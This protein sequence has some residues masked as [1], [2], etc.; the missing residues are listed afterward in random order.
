MTDQ[1]TPV[2]WWVRRDFRLADNP[3]LTAALQNGAPVVPLYV[4]D[5]QD[6]GLGA[7]PKFRLGLAIEHFAKTLAALG[8]RLILRRG[9][10]LSVLKDLMR[11]T[12]AR[13][14]HWSRLYDPEA[15]ARD[16]QIKEQLKARG[17]EARSHG[18]RLLF[19]PWTVQNKAG[20][21]FRVYTPFWKTVCQRNPDALIPPPERLKSPANWP[22]SDDLNDWA[23][24]AAMNRGAEVLRRHCHVGE[25][26]A[27][28]RLQ[29]FLD[30]RVA[31]Y[32]ERRD[33]PA[34]DATSG[35]SEN[36]AW[37]E[38]SPHRMWHLG[39]RAMEGCAGD[40]AEHFLKEIVW[41]EFSYHLM[42][43]TPEILNRNWRSEWDGFPWQAVDDD[44][45]RAWRQGQT[46]YD[47]VDAA[48]RQLYVTGKMHNRARMLVASFLTKHLMTH[49]KI[50]MDWF[51]DCL[52]DWDP[53]ANAMGW[54][55]TAGSGPDAAPFFRIFNPD[56]QLDK[57]DKDRRY[58]RH[59]IA[60]GHPVA[61]ADA[62]AFFD[63][64]PR[65]WNLSAN[66]LRARPIV[67]LKAGR[68][69]ALAAYA[70]RPK[71]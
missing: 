4:L 15:I 34:E 54:Q 1:K 42:Y 28:E 67:D 13:S 21:M 63:A 14:V 26:L 10:A 33:F 64:V 53:A 56:G 6:E 29:H 71:P 62:R 27:L 5:P 20:A 23:M 46:G 59:W 25:D 18:G 7:A 60:E 22:H 70:G 43:H 52:V 47:F 32:K 55:W 50:G 51:S 36:L 68:E 12:G 3:A 37:G 58:V 2:I 61:S 17:F 57:F 40:G 41:R 19:E 11:E 9:A 38:I 48:M 24:A 39:L 49:W 35:L 65:S 69:A 30:N 45:V 66:Q 31:F 16:S 44:R 8:S